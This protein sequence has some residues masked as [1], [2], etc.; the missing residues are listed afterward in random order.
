[1]RVWLGLDG[2]ES[3]VICDWVIMLALIAQMRVSFTFA[4]SPESNSL[5]GIYLPSFSPKAESRAEVGG[6]VLLYNESKSRVGN[7][8]K[9]K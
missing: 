2:S 5:T 9:G 3:G 4:P 8:L 6:E 7:L 1:M